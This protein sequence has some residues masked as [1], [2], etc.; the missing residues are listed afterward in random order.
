ETSPP[1]S[2]PAQKPR[3]S[4]A[5][6]QSPNASVAE[7]VEK[8]RGLMAVDQV[9]QAEKLLRK[10]VAIQPDNWR[11][12]STLASVLKYDG[13]SDEAVKLLQVGLTDETDTTNRVNSLVFIGRLSQQRAEDGP[14]VTQRRGMIEASPSKP[15]VDEDAFKQKHLAIAEN[16]F[17]ELNSI[18]PD[19][20]D[21]TQFLASTLSLAG[22]LE[23]AIE[24]WE[25]QLQREPKNRTAIVQLASLNFKAGNPVIAIKLV[26]DF[27]EK[28]PNDSEVIALLV[29]HYRETKQS[30]EQE[31]WEV[32]HDFSQRVPPFSK[33][34]YSEESLAKLD[35]LKTNSRVEELLLLK[36][37]ESTNLLAIYC[38][39][40][41]HNDLEDRAFE[42]LGNRGANQLLDQLFKHA[43]STCTIRGAAAQLARSK[44]DD[45]YDQLIR[46][47]PNDRRGVGMHM[48]IANALDI[49]NDRRAVPM[50]VAV[51]A[52]ENMSRQDR[53][54]A[55][56][57]DVDGARRRAAIAL[58]SFDTEESKSAL[59]TGTGNPSISFA[60][61]AALYRL[62][63]EE[64]YLP[65]LKDT[66]PRDM[67][68]TRRILRRLKEKLP[69]DKPLDALLEAIQRQ[70]D[71]K[72]KAS[73][74]SP[75]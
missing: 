62:T 57:Q 14:N 51:L 16:A 50:L 49:L 9:E 29:N 1:S 46:L 36:E 55:Y 58:G 31:H 6:V 12:R 10:S 15:R 38:W 65:D 73:S 20:P 68:R 61:T 47:L 48:D 25:K 63:G 17:R 35:S 28:Q 13:R 43:G 45:L 67:Y 41:P 42:E 37:A 11:L 3:S 26:T 72:I 75:D 8:V 54:M 40:H 60:C 21:F 22:K 44:P 56:M 71:E 34:T 23:E 32:R 70:I 74:E 53:M 7:I 64:E 59:V 30:D 5:A 33:L 69:Q 27:L 66:D 18:A 24:L 2:P 39:S 4:E 52:P 19:H